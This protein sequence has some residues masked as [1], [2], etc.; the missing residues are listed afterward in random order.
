M[1]TRPKRA[2]AKKP[3]ARRRPSGAVSIPLVIIL[4]A[5]AA[6]IA[7]ILVTVRSNSDDQIPMIGLGFAALGASLAALAIGSLVGMWRAASRANGRRA[8]G[9]AMVGGVAA[10]SAI[11]S[12]TVTL[13]SMLVWNS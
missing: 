6:S 1:T 9:L 5:I 7:F 10:L 8:F 4:L 13:L 3:A 11:G 12:F 2:R